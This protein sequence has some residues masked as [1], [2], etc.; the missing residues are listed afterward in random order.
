M[1][2][3]EIITNLLREIIPNVEVDVCETEFYEKYVQI[4][5]RSDDCIPY[6]LPR[7]KKVVLG[8]TADGKWWDSEVK[9]E[10]DIF[11][12]IISKYHNDI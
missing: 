6:T 1:T 4:T 7:I 10:E 2:N 8:L 9:N 5:G 12:N 3:G 11:N